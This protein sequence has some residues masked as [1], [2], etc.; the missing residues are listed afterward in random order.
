MS[1]R[2]LSTFMFLALSQCVSFWK[3]APNYDSRILSVQ[4]LSLFTQRENSSLS[5]TPWVGDWIFRRERLQLIDNELRESKPDIIIL[6]EAMERKGSPSESDRSILAAGALIGYDWNEL[7]IKEFIDVQEVQFM[8]TAVGL[9]LRIAEVD[10]EK[11]QILWSVGVDGYLAITEIDFEDQPMVV[12]NVQMPPKM[13]RNFL[14]YTFVQERIQDFLKGNKICPKRAIIAGYLPTEE[15]SQRFESFLQEMQLKDSSLGLCQ[16]A[17]SCYTATPT[18]EIF[19]ATAPSETP[20]LV[21]RILIHQSAIVYSGVRNFDHSAPPTEYSRSFGI[22][23]IFPTQRFG[24]KASIRLAKC[25]KDE[26]L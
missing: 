15:G 3:F 4:T 22:N 1:R 16:I 19:M 21:D 23:R 2:F 8:T 5:Q 14:W 10:P 12:F 11:T 9:P 25:S 6:Q 24:W 7:P 26:F 20:A 18:N 13:G 17:N